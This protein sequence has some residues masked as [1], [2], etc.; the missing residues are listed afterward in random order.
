MSFA[1][2]TLRCCSKKYK[3]L[4]PDNRKCGK[5]EDYRSASLFNIQGKKAIVTGGTR[6]LGR[7]M[8]ICLLENGCDVVAVSRNI[9]GNEDMLEIAK[10]SG[11]NFYL[12]ACDVCDTDAVVGM[13]AYAR[14]TM[15]RIDILVNSAGKN[16][17]R[18][19][20]DMD[21]ESWDSVLDLNLRANFIV[22]R[23]VVKVMK[24]QKYGKII[25]MSSMKSI[26]GVSDSGYSAYCA[27]KGAV[28]MLSKQIACEVAA[29]HITVNVLAPTFI[30]TAINRHQLADP[31]FK[32]ALEARIPVGRIGQFRD[33][34][35]PLLLLASD[36]SEF[37]TGQVILLEG[38]L[39]ARQ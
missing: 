5:M 21:D 7:E 10:K 27:S 4:K 36:A 1:G 16:I 20:T 9:Q 24:E 26:L 22:M 17:T 25:N 38:G 33:L 6:G 31:A 18:M 39:A 23:E 29:D 28:N 30:E 37:I 12:H 15:G 34:M 14:D 35:G 13:V 2:M 8:A 3:G 19:V 11:A 32:G